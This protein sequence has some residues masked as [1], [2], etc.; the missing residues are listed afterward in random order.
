M[1][2][3]EEHKAIFL[4]TETVHVGVFKIEDEKVFLQQKTWLGFRKNWI[5][6]L[7]NVNGHL[8]TY[9]ERHLITCADGRC[10]DKIR[11]YFYDLDTFKAFTSMT[12]ARAERALASLEAENNLLFQKVSELQEMSSNGNIMQMQSRLKDLWDW[13]NKLKPTYIS[14]TGDKDKKKV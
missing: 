14:P 10:D 6:V 5:P 12:N 3:E 2:K 8:K 1:V 4:G 13:T 9:E 7:S 11:I